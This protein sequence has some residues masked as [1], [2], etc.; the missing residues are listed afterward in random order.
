MCLWC[1]LIPK[2]RTLAEPCVFCGGCSQLLPSVLVIAQVSSLLHNVPRCNAGHV[3]IQQCRSL[4]VK[5]ILAKLQDTSSF[6]CHTPVLAQFKPF[7]NTNCQPHLSWWYVCTLFTYLSMLTFSVIAPPYPRS[8]QSITTRMCTM[9]TGS[10]CSKRSPQRSHKAFRGAPAGCRYMRTLKC[11]LCCLYFR[12]YISCVE[13]EQPCTLS[14]YDMALAEGSYH[15][16]LHTSACSTA[17]PSV[18]TTA[19]SLLQ[20]VPCLLVVLYQLN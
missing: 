5:L 8:L 9:H 15:F 3:S 18:S 14:A 10:V 12:S 11:L 2:E 16:L 20:S 19:C 6:P 4:A 17:V 1:D 7:H 13:P